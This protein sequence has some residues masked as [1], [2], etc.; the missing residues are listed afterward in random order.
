MNLKNRLVNALPR[1]LLSGVRPALPGKLEA[2]LL[3]LPLRNELEIRRALREGRR[4]VFVSSYPR[5]GNTW[6]R[7]LMA[8]LILQKNGYQTDTTLPVHHD[9]VIPDRDFNALGEIP[10]LERV[11]GLTVKTHDRYGAVTRLYPAS[12]REQV[13]HLYLF[14]DP[15]D[16][17]V[18]YYHFH[19]RYDHLKA[20]LKGTGID[21]F[22]LQRAEEWKAH[23]E[24]Y[25]DAVEGEDRSIFLG[26]Y[27]A[28]SDDPVPL[29]QALFEWLDYP[30]SRE[31]AERAVDHHR[32]RK[33]QRKEARDPVNREELFYRKGKVGGGRAELSAETVEELQRRCGGILGR[34]R[35]LVAR[36]VPG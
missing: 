22:C 8:D 10:A 13:R 33:L 24:G 31:E 9:R 4:V 35:K 2:W 18:S 14:R 34:A 17:L 7:K 20:A 16:A 28:L 5:S 32:F 36:R 30:V 29:L 21:T 3:P 23:V 11:P 1:G 6:M 25:L 27:E 26:S 15:A 12:R 19:H